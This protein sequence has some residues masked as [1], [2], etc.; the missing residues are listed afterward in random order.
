MHAIIG[1]KMIRWVSSILILLIFLSGACMREK[2]DKSVITVSIPPQKYIIEK[3]VGE[4]YQVNSLLA[5]GVNPE[6]YDPTMNDL[7]DLQKSCVYFQL[8]NIGFEAAALSRISDNFP[9]L[10]IINTSDGISLLTGTHGDHDKEIDPHVWV[11]VRNVK[12][13]AA[14]MYETMIKINP[15]EKE[16][17]TS[18]YDSF[19]KELDVLDD[20][21]SCLLSGCGGE[22]FIVWHPSLSYFAR[23]YDLNQISIESGGKEVSPRQLKERIDIAK[24]SGA[25]VFFVQKEYDGNKGH[26]VNVEIG[27]ELVEI[28]LMDYDWPEQMMNIAHALVSKKNN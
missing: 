8:G 1:I 14:K 2:S 23:D 19:I 28:S 20:S 5:A 24:H 12:H 27:A 17:F 25:K 9:S 11:S 18:R 15:V 6:T 26:Q 16:Y 13:I 21:I 4:R 10:R 3:I 7:V 22:S